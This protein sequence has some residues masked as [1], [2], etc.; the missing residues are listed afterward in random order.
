MSG[1]SKLTYQQIITI[2]EERAHGGWTLK[3]LAARHGVSPMTVSR[4][5]T[6][7]AHPHIPGPITP[8]N[9]TAPK[10]TC[11][12]GHRLNRENRRSGARWRDCKS[13]HTIR[14]REYRHRK[15][16]QTR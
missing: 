10:R 11:W 6:G 2:R 8:K 4:V 13:C 9:T 14:N 1:G 3:E 15:E 12:R 5:T 7:D 16:A